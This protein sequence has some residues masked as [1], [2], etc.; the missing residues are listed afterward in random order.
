MENRVQVIFEA[1]NRTKA[2]FQE[3]WKD[4]DNFRLKASELDGFLKQGIGLG[5]FYGLI[6]ES[7]T[8]IDTIERTENS[9]KGLA[10]VARYAGEDIGTSLDT[11]MALAADGLINV[12]EASQ[13]LQNLLS[14]GYS[15]DESVAI[16]N[17]LK[18]AAAFNRQANLSMGEAIKGATE[19]LK[20]ENSVLVDNA[21]VT[22]NVSVMWKEYAQEIGTTVDKLTLSQK[23]QAEYNGI[24][25]ETEA[26]VGNAKLAVDGITGAKS[27]MRQE[28]FMLN[29][30]L[31]QSL[32]PA[33][34][35][36]GGT[37]GWVLEQ[38]RSF[39]GMIEIT[40]LSYGNW[41]AK[42][43]ATID[44]MKGGFS[45]G[46]AALKEEFI[47]FDNY[48]D[49][50]VN[51]IVR[52]WDGEISVPDIGADSGKRRKDTPPP[53]DQAAAK[54]AAQQAE[55]WA[56]VA[57]DLRTDMAKIGLD[58][59]GQKLADL[60]AKAEELRGKPKSDNGLIGEW[61][62]GMT[63]QAIAD[64]IKKLDQEIADL[65]I[66]RAE[67][68]AEWEEGLKRRAAAARAAREAEI[69]YQLSVIDT[70]E[71]FL[72][73]DKTAATERRIVLTRE[74]LA[75]Q[76]QFAAQI[77]RATDPTGWYTQQQAIEATR[78]K[79]LELALVM[80]E[81]SGT[82]GEGM[83]RGLRKFTDDARTMF[84]LGEDFAKQTAQNMEQ[85]FS[86]FFFTMMEGKFK[87]LGDVIVS[88][89]QA[90]QR[91][92]ADVLAQMA[93]EQIMKGVA[94]F[95]M[96]LFSA[97]TGHSGYS[98]GSFDW[99]AEVDHDGGA[100]G[101]GGAPARRYVPRFHFGGLAT[102][103]IPAILQRGEYVVSR[104]GVAALDRINRGEVGGG[105]PA[106]TIN[107]ENKSGAALDA[108]VGDMRLDPSGWVIDVVLSDLGSYGK[109]YHAMQGIR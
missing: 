24:M 14:R 18:D 55:A 104:R 13:S 97:S 95:A 103:E 106:V 37:V 33:F 66:K 19:G 96:N 79:L 21:G 20:N 28:V 5:M 91:S 1:L 32:T 74:L 44:W 16:L 71:K 100:V 12:Q 80:E 62:L 10:A 105:A 25:R 7:R 70:Q 29:N 93:T 30:A 86:D 59:L 61:L 15:L 60:N 65:E 89:L 99:S 98:G 51:K 54:K 56:K 76:E 67:G 36:F 50:Q 72:Q 102:D 45:G 92:I 81:R 11:A 42:I 40:G 77:D 85:S 35:L 43:G 84:Q 46:F 68:E 31:G 8:A 64:E 34:R 26:Q 47:T 75:V 2:T 57:A 17:R 87:S 78:E 3:L 73:I 27:R 108:K 22:K 107:L 90:V 53:G 41:A 101:R 52:K 83:T 109:L 23:R 63:N 88:F 9:V 82:F 69:N 38:V 4:T 39:L 58:E 94:N 6:N 49:E 48:F